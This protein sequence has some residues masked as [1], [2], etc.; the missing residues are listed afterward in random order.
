MI[1]T[2]DL[3]EMIDGETSLVLPSDIQDYLIANLDVDKI[4]NKIDTS[5]IVDYVLNM[6]LSEKQKEKI[7]E[8]E[9]DFDD[10]LV[11][12]KGQFLNLGEKLDV[13]DAIDFDEDDAIE[14]LESF[15][16]LT[17]RQRNKLKDMLDIDSHNDNFIINSLSDKIKFETIQEIFK[18]ATEQQLDEFLKTLK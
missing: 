10:L 2:E 4:L 1:Y 15:S 18:K 5:D 12:L 17:D 16:M 8:K 6:G 9:L 13:L 7:F 11:C 14:Y 3:R